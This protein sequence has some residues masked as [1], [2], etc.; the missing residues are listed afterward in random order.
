MNTRLFCLHSF[1]GSVGVGICA[2][3]KL[4]SDGYN[5]ESCGTTAWTG[6]ADDVL[7]MALLTDGFSGRW[8]DRHRTI[9]GGIEDLAILVS[10]LL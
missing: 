3:Y 4:N 1:A 2:M 10:T 8:H 6:L 9:V 7:A 5:L